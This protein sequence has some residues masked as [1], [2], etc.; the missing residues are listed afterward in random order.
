MKPIKKSSKKERVV[1][2]KAWLICDGKG[3]PLDFG[4]INDKPCERM[5]FVYSSKK[6]ADRQWAGFKMIE[7]TFSYPFTS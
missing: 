5:L 7:I 4:S 1:K 3:K 2:V 6:E